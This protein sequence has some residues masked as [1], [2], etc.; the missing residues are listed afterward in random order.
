VLPRS[1]L[2]S[3][4]LP[5]ATRVLLSERLPEQVWDLE[6]RQR[7]RGREALFLLNRCS[8]FT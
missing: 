3:A 8:P 7:L 5:E 1:A 4:P 6:L 2:R